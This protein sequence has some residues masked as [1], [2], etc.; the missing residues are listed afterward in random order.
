MSSIDESMKQK[1]EKAIDSFID[2]SASQYTAQELNE[3]FSSGEKAIALLRAYIERK[4][5]E[6]KNTAHW[7][8]ISVRANI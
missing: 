1:M 8:S 6:A 7:S 4:A 2:E 5:K 3:M